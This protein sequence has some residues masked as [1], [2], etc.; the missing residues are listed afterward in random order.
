MILET[1]NQLQS[2]LVGHRDRAA[3]A[4]LKENI[5][6]FN[7]NRLRKAADFSHRSQDGWTER[8]LAHVAVSPC[9]SDQGGKIFW[10]VLSL[11]FGAVSRFRFLPCGGSAS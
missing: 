11:F 4:V 2:D 1:L 7:P 3:S 5:S 6:V 10:I 9:V 8:Q